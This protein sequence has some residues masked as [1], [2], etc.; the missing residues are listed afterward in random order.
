MKK[1][2]QE[3]ILA[4]I[5]IGFSLSMYE[6]HYLLF[7]DLHHILLYFI[8]DIAFLGVQ[9]LIAYF[10][11]D[12][13]LSYRE[14]MA[15]M[16]KLNMLAG[17]FFYDI[18]IKIFNL[19]SSQLTECQ[20]CATHVCVQ[21]NWTNKDFQ[22]NTQKIPHLA[23]SLR[24]E[25]KAMQTLAKELSSAKDMI[26]RLMENSSLHE[27]ES[28]SDML[29]ALFHLT[30]ELLRRDSLETNTAEDKKHLANDMKRVYIH[31][32]QLWLEYMQHLKDN[33]YYLYLYNIRNRQLNIGTVK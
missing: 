23:I 3:F 8:G 20:D 4:I 15:T 19:L 13:L 10:A 26:I 9:A 27:H 32:S 17:I 11:F 7:H 30:E 21:E 16:K 22:R 5:L 25:P 1:Y 24:Y 14:N 28:F 6:L 31:M 18:G 33:Y 29:L 2:A 12:R